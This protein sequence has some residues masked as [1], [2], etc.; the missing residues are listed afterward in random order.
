MVVK[1]C[2]DAIAPATDEGHDVLAAAYGC[3]CY[4]QDGGSAGSFPMDDDE[5]S[6]S[7]APGH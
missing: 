5:F 3:V 4:R 2:C 7:P 1:L 6:C